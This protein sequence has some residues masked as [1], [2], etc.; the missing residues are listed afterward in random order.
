MR[1]QKTEAIAETA[2]CTGSRSVV[3]GA[4]TVPCLRH[5]VPGDRI[6]RIVRAG[7]MPA[8]GTHKGCPYVAIPS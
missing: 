8:L 3:R 5:W 4:N 7:L 6:V 1:P 2:V